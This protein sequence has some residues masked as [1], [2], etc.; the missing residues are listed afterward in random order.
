[1]QV[2]PYLFFNGN[3]GAALDFYQT[4]LGAEVT[5]RHTVAESPVAAD[6]PAEAQANIMHASLKI[7]DSTIMLSD[8]CPGQPAPAMQG[9]ALTIA[10]DDL[11]RGEQIFNALAVGGSV[12][13]PFAATFWA[14]GFGH[15]NDQ[16]GVSWMINVE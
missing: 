14:K 5:F 15:V 13:M 16:Y 12:C 6:F 7:G 4:V 10:V 9:C 11:A 2:S 1:M 3:A 8:G